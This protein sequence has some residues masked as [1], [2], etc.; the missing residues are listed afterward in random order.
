MIQ[1]NAPD[2]VKL[3]MQ[4]SYEWILS[5][6][7]SSSNDFQFKCCATLIEL[8]ENMYK[9]EQQIKTALSELKYALDNQEIK[10]SVE[11]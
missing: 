2:K 5:C 10:F 7:K 11:V 8:F 9:D 3:L 1:G 4:T 6:I